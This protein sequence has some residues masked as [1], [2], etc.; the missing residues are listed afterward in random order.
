MHGNI[1]DAINAET[2]SVVESMKPTKVEGQTLAGFMTGFPHLSRGEI[3]SALRVAIA[4]HLWVERYQTHRVVQGG[5]VHTGRRPRVGLWAGL[6]GSGP[7]S[8]NSRRREV[9]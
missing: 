9:I 4:G 6:E 7:P 8:L 1:A 5:K 2:E 3:L